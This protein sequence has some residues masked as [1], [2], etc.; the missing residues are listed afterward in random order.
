MLLTFL[1]AMLALI[2][3]VIGCAVMNP[4]Y[5]AYVVDDPDTGAADR[6]SSI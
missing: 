6:K 3:A 2:L 5:H 1:V 4:G